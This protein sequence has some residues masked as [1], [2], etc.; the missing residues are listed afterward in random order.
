MK[1]PSQSTSGTNCFPACHWTELEVQALHVL[2]HRRQSLGAEDLLLDKHPTPQDRCC[3]VKEASLLRVF[4]LGS[5]LPSLR[6][7]AR[8]R[9]Q[10]YALRPSSPQCQLTGTGP[11]VPSLSQLPRL[12]WDML[13]TRLLPCSQDFSFE[14]TVLSIELINYSSSVPRVSPVCHCCVLAHRARGKAQK[15]CSVSRCGIVN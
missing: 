2:G 6:L 4:I 7:R 14:L 5:P 12:L 9:A 8:G 10:T 13:C 15:W 3:H 1:C 11:V